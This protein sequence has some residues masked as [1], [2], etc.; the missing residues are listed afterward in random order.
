MIERPNRAVLT[1]ALDEFRDAMR[2]FVV[3]GMRRVRGKAVEDAIYESL[4][5]NQAS[6]FNRNLQNNGSIES[7]I[8][9]GDFP[10]LVRKNWWQ[11]FSQ[12][13]GDNMNVQN[14]L[15]IIKEARDSAAH[16]IDRGFRC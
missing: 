9:I 8:D 14:A 13:F 15:Y 5:P 2:P 4:S 10:N 7:A 16:P 11:V 1:D 12:Q 3:C 6:Q